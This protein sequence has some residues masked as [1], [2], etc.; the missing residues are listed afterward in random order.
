MIAAFT[1]GTYHFDFSLR[2]YFLCD[3][4]AFSAIEELSMVAVT[5]LGRGVSYVGTSFQAVV[6]DIGGR[7]HC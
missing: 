5:F 2:G 3:F 1:F 4:L 6:E 7:G